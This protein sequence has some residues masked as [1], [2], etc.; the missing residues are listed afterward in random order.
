MFVVSLLV[1][2]WL[3]STNLWSTD[4][5]KIKQLHIELN[6]IELQAGAV[7]KLIATAQEQL[8]KKAN[9]P[10]TEAKVD[11]RIKQMLTRKVTDPNDEIN[12]TV[13]LL[14]TKATGGRLQVNK[15]EMGD[16]VEKASFSLI[17]ITVVFSAPYTAVQNYLDTI[18][19][20]NRPLVVSSFQMKSEP[21]APGVLDVTIVVDLYIAK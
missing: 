10:V 18:E 12:S 15:I 2:F 6:G 19:R 20:M 9:A 4:S 16:K 13:D 21:D 1:I 7:K 17:P 8:T 11:D 3:F 5:D 14:S